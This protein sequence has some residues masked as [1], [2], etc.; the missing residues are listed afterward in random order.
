MELAVLNQASAANRRLAA[1]A[2]WLAVCFVAVKAYYLGAPKIG[3]VE[4]RD[5]LGNLAA[6]SYGDVLFAVWF[7]AAARTALAAAR[8]PRVR[9]AVS[10][11]VAAIAAFCTLYAVANIVVF[12]IFGGFV[13]YPLLSL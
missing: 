5:Y 11:I 6:T 13:S 7:W 2:V 10:K 8:R 12:G 3:V 9:A 1:A 4:W